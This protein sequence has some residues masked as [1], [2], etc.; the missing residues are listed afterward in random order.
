MAVPQSGP[1]TNRPCSRAVR[2][3]RDLV[4]DRHVVAEQHDVQAEPQC[5][6]QPRPRRTRPASR[7]ARR[8]AS[9]APL[10]RHLQARRRQHARAAVRRCLGR[11]A[12][13]RFRGRQRGFERARS[14]AP[15]TTTRRSLVP[16]S[17][18][19]SSNPASR[20]MSRLARRRH[21]SPTP[22]R[23]RAGRAVAA[24]SCIIDTE[25][26]YTFRTTRYA[27]GMLLLVATSAGRIA[28]QRRRR[29]DLYT[30]WYTSV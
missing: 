26:R 20:S 17:G 29:C 7:S 30:N 6:A 19:P 13:L 2:L 14:R 11:L 22:A 27:V 12:K 9:G 3:E 8:F 28:W 10:Q 1:I 15:L 24:E 25:S 5:L 16:A 18:S 23:R 4:V 21:R